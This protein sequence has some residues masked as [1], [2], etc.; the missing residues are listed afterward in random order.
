METK[1]QVILHNIADTIKNFDMPAGSQQN[2]G[3]FIL[4]DK[5][6]SPYILTLPKFIRSKEELEGEYIINY[7]IFDGLTK[8]H[9]ADLFMAFKERSSF[10]ATIE[11]LKEQYLRSHLGSGILRLYEY[12][13]YIHGYNYVNGT[14][15]CL[16]KDFIRKNKLKNFYQ[17][18]GYTTKK[19]RL[20]K[21]IDIDEMKN[22][23]KDL[24]TINHNDL[25]YKILLPHEQKHEIISLLTTLKTTNCRV[26]ENTDL[27]Y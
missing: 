17:K 8:E 16:N 24:I 1:A 18:N 19:G 9:I 23:T 27:I 3:Y 10:L 12:F 5:N 7:D 26:G 20:H 11:I 22:F 14:I 25:Q 2:D 6:D 13:S 15:D 4:F 21:H